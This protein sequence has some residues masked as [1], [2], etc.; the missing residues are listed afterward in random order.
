MDCQA[1]KLEPIKHDRARLATFK[2]RKHSLLKKADELATLCDVEACIIIYG[3]KLKGQSAKPETW[4][5]KDGDLNSIIRKYKKKISAGGDHDQKRMSCLSKFDETRGK[6]VD[7]ASAARTRR[8][9][10][11]GN[12][13]TWDQRIES[14]SEDQLK[15]IL[16]TMDDKLKVADRKLN[17]IKLEHDSLSNELQPESSDM[18]TQRGGESGSS[19]TLTQS[20]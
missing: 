20:P 3:P 10:C 16:G 7:D 4:S 14:L 9:N 19:I 18:E 13:T 1:L 12:F 11:V 2:K 6:Q 15:M 17:M 8:K 5:S